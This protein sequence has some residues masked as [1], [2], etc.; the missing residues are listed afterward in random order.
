MIY[1]LANLIVLGCFSVLAIYSY[2]R[3]VTRLV[4]V[5]T[6]A[7]RPTAE[8]DFLDDVADPV[9][10]RA[11][12]GYNLSDVAAHLRMMKSITKE[13]RAAEKQA[14]PHTISVAD[15]GGY[16]ACAL[17]KKFN[18]TPCRSNQ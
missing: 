9:V 1:R 4:P 10:L 14:T 2:Q 6:V 16:G 15:A 3:E 17:R 8:V 12:A 18:L 5:H 7:M 11:K 13:E